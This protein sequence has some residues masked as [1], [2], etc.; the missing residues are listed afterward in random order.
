MDFTVREWMMTL[1]VYVDPDA[2]V[3]EALSLM[4]RRYIN[5]LVVKKTETNPEYG[6][7][8]TVDVCDKII[9]QNRDPSKLK[10]RDIMTSPLIS[11]S[12][13]ASIQDCAKL[14][15][16]LKNRHLPVRD[17]ET[18]ELIGMVSATDFLVIAEAMAS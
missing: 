17:D 14:M 4:R 7:V 2:T 5:S 10:V 8:T 11:I 6:I 15:M 3:K 13:S 16:S 18:G 1:I 9:A 12:Q